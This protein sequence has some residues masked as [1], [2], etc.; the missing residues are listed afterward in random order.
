VGRHSRATRTAAP[1]PT[2]AV[3]PGSQLSAGA[4]RPILEILEPGLLSTIQ[5]GGRPGYAHL[6]VPISG[7]CD[8]WGLAQANLL[9]GN[10]AAAAAI[11]ITLSGPAIR[12]LEECVL[13][14][15]GADLGAHVP[16]EYRDLMVGAAHLLRGG[17]SVR[18]R[19]GRPGARSGNAAGMRSYLAVA[20]GV[21]VPLVLGSAATY[22]AGGFG[23]IEGRALRAGDRVHA[24]TRGG[25][26]GAGR[27]WPAR[28]G[29]PPYDSASP[30]RVLRGPHA[31]LVGAAFVDGLLAATWRVQP[32]SDRRG[33]RLAA[34]ED[35]AP[36]AEAPEIA[37]LPMV[38][39]A[40]QVPPDGRPIVLLAD[41]QTVGGY[42]V[43]AVVI[44]ADWPR[45]GQLSPGFD[46]RFALVSIEQAEEA[47][48]KQQSDLD[49]AR[50]A[51]AGTDAWEVLADAAG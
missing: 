31:D 20:G 8:P 35:L 21:D 49:A 4:N 18:F 33:V 17:T 37:S 51:M 42:P 43:A 13:G 22:L 44:R 48:R 23:G 19:N 46:I 15:G 45:L 34:D 38:W 36:S 27:I 3:P 29:P 47:W 6:G 16:E 11:E 39:G 5:D 1:W 32:Q 25:V 2:R 10:D 7:A 41:H 12:V 40:V 50:R 24:R 14:I 26:G 30:L 9:V 28:V